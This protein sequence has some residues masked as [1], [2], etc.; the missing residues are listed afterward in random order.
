M[1]LRLA[2][3]QSNCPVGNVLTPLN[4]CEVSADNSYKALQGKDKMTPIFK[5][6]LSWLIDKHLSES[7]FMGLPVNVLDRSEL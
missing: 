5:D 7:F 6:Y 2:L 4:C 3:Y 1:A